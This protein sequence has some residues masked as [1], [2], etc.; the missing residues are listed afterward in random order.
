MPSSKLLIVDDEES[1]RK[2]LEWAFKNDFTVIEAASPEEALEAVK[3][4]HPDLMILDLALTGDPENLEGFSILES[5][6]LIDPR[7]KIIVVTGHDER[8]NALAAIAKGAYDFYAKPL[9][10]EELKVIMKRGESLLSLERENERLRKAAGEE[11][12][13]EGIIAMSPPMLETFDTVKR[14]APTDVNV[15]ITG[16]SGTG[17]ELIAKAIHQKSSRRSKPFVPINCGAI[18]EN[19]L[20]SELFG[21]E[22]GSF[23]GAHMTR[24]GKFETADGGTIFLDEIGELS[25]NLQVKLLR[26]LQDHI[27]ER[28]GGREPIRVDVRI[29]AATNRDL[30]IMIE[31][32]TFREDLYYRINTIGINLPPLSGRGEDILLL[33]MHFLHRYNTEFSKNIRGFSDAALKSIYGYGWPGN[34]RELENRVKRA[35]IMSPRKVIGPD[36]LDLQESAEE[37]GAPAPGAGKGVR[38]DSG[39]FEPTTLREARDRVERRLLTGSLLRTSGN[40]SAAAQE[41]G[42]SRPTLHDLLKKHGIDPQSYRR[43]E[44]T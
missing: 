1:I 38:P 5:A 17:K 4:N 7:I 23:T 21:H 39:A 2:Q 24:P 44:R 19:L 25:P 41:L 3:S 10:I 29:I 40:V 35:V 42:V 27:I 8:K 34:V 28:I 16:E 33:G 31:E 43:R 30:R 32:R 18:P 15:L 22:K 37:E 20:E 12:E 6:L 36:D 9:E 14:V 11:H 26:F 13:F